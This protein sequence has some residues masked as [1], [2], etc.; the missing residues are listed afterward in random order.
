MQDIEVP[1]GEDNPFDVCVPED[2]DLLTGGDDMLEEDQ[3]GLLEEHQGEAATPSSPEKEENKPDEESRVGTP[4][5]LSPELWKTNK[6]TKM[7]D[8]WALGVILYELCCF[9]YPFPAD[10]LE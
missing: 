9:K 1:K 3:G 4:Y 6:C 10:S 7:S 2:D 8:I 5:Y